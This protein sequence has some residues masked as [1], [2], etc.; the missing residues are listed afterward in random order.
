MFEWLEQ[1]LRTIKTK[2]FHVVDGPTDPAQQAAVAENGVPVPGSY[3]EFVRR[4]GNA[5]LYKKMG[6]YLAGVV[7]PPMEEEEFREGERLYRIGH[8]QSSDAYFKA[9]LLRGTDEV[10]VFEGHG[11]RWVQVADSFE[12]WLTKRCRA[13]RKTYSK[14]EWA[15]V[16]AGPPPFSPEEH[17]IVEARRR[18]TWRLKGVTPHQSLLIEVTNGSEMVL[19]YLSIGVRWKDNSLEGGIWLPVSHVHPGQTA[20]VEHKGYS[21]EADPKEVEVFSLPDP[22]PEDRGRYWEFRALSA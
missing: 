1:E 19:P 6:Y 5:K 9:A 8:Y 22:E 18:F 15:K 20:V 16:V 13:A 11:G 14:A 7:A 4:F 10:P 21:S 3:Q 17:R 12:A 2:R